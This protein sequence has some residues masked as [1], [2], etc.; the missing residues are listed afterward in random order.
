MPRPIRKPERLHLR[1][2]PDLRERA[3]DKAA[4]KGLTLSEVI[5]RLLK[6]WVEGEVE[7]NDR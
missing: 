2:E 5:R 6:K 3:M 1:L 7:V 4:R